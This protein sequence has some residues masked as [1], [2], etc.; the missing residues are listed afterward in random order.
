[1][2]SS[3]ETLGKSFK[4]AENVPDK[5][6]VRP[7]P[8]LRRRVVLVF[9]LVLASVVLAL[10]AWQWQARRALD[11]RI[12]ALRSA[13]ERVL[14]SDFA[15]APADYDPQGNAACDL[16]AAAAIL[17]D[18]SPES[19]SISF[20]PTTLPVNPRAWPYLARATDWFEPAL[21]RLERA[22]AKPRL[23]WKH[24][25]RSPLTENLLVPE[26][27]GNRSLAELVM[28]AAFVEH[29]RGQDLSVVRRFGQ[30]LYLSD[31]CDQTPAFVG[32]LCA[33]WIAG[34]A[35]A[36]IE[37]I[38]PELR[39]AQES[40]AATQAS[41]RALIA[42]LLDDAPSSK[43]LLLALQ[44]ERMMNLDRVDSIARGVRSFNG[45]LDPITRYMVGA[46]LLNKARVVLDHD[47]ATLSALRDASD[48]PTAKT[49]LDAIK[50]IGDRAFIVDSLPTIRRAVEIHFLTVTDRRMAA[51]ALAIRLYQMN[52][53][54]QIPQRLDQ[55]I[56]DYLPSVPADAM[57]S[58]GHP[59]GYLPRPHHPVLYSVGLNGIDDTASE[60]PM[61]GLHGEINEW[62][63]LDRA[64]YLTNTPREVVYVA[65]PNATGSPG[66]IGPI[67]MDFDPRPPWEREV[68]SP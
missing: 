18:Y 37:Q 11:R 51:T 66:Y 63:R 10:A 17:D 48:W 33:L 32:H 3:S 53:A 52:H 45:E 15:P 4:M 5:V 16:V 56:P 13:G 43:G 62:H 20:A 27:N 68:R 9:I 25:F 12:E 7:P 29:H 34:S 21:R 23:Q 50:P 22:H 58:S 39:I 60:A 30:M 46:D 44:S 61:P 35:S 26:L 55:L 54:G 67:G 24:D 38:A 1:M 14:P 19:D 64:F 49:R 42:Q 65:P 36:R 2:C 57:A 31:A 6:T 47:T 28:A 8:R 59:I 40:G 41:V